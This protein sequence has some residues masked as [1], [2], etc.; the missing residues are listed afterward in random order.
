MPLLGREHKL[1]S[2]DPFRLLQEQRIIT[3]DEAWIPYFNPET[4]SQ[5]K[6]W[7]KPEEGPPPRATAVPS[8]RKW[9]LPRSWEAGEKWDVY[10]WK[11]PRRERIDIVNFLSK[12]KPQ[13]YVGETAR[14]LL[15][16]Q[17]CSL[18]LIYDLNGVKQRLQ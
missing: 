7:R 1:N 11:Q 4:K 10:Y 5:S 15:R 16:K 3:T 8:L 9:P 6:E 17:F 18:L 2:S 12:S 13:S 14:S